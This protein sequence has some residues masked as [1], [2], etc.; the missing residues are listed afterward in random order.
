MVS[1]IT[2]RVSLR[3]DVSD[4]RERCVRVCSQVERVR[5][6]AKQVAD[7]AALFAFS[8]G[9]SQFYLQLEDDV[10]CAAGFVAGVR[11]FIRQQ[12]SVW[13]MLEFSE[14]GFIG[15]LFRCSRICAT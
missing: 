8:A 1:R 12:N 2:V 10:Q 5:W 9:Q 14:L 15:K 6:R 11:R 4:W 13:A 7:Y 3:L